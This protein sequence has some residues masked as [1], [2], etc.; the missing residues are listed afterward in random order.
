MRLAGLAGLNVAPV[1]LTRSMDK[2]VLLVKRFDREQHGRGNHAARHGV[3]AHPVR[4]G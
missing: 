1:R 2:D 3:G 4:T